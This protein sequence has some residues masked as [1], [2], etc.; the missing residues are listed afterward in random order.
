MKRVPCTST[1]SISPAQSAGAKSPRSPWY[2]RPG[3]P[4]LDAGTDPCLR[5]R[6]RCVHGVEISR[7]HDMRHWP[8]RQDFFGDRRCDIAWRMQHKFAGGE[9]DYRHSCIEPR[10]QHSNGIR[11][12]PNLICDIGREEHCVHAKTKIARILSVLEAGVHQS[13]PRGPESAHR[14]AISGALL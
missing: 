12:K 4:S 8:D 2:F 9:P 5:L 3:A 14:L 11:A 7:R 1:W 10:T 6:G 13:A